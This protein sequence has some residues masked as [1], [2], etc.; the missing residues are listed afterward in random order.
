[1]Q[2]ADSINT[3]DKIRGELLKYESKEN[4]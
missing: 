3:L 2:Y 1:M 4:L